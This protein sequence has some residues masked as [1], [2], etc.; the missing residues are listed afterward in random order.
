MAGVSRS[1]AIKSARLPGSIVPTRSAKPS[2]QAPPSVAMAITSGAGSTVGSALE[3]LASKAARRASANRSRPLLDAA[4]SVPTATTVSAARNLATGQTPLAS[5]M[6]ECGQWITRTPRSAA[7]RISSSVTA[8]MWTACRFSFSSPI[9]SRSC[10]QLL[11]HCF[12]ASATSSAVSCR[13]MWTLAS[14]SSASMATRSKVL[15][16]TA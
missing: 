8:V 16:S 15:R 10:I 11:P 9:A 4:P 6:L 13:W 5:F 14:T 3:L 1:T 12:R 7:K 2:A